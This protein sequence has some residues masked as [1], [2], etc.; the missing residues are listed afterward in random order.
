MAILPC[1][2]HYSD[3][4]MFTAALESAFDIAARRSS[5]VVLL[6]APP[7]G[8]E[9][10]YGWIEL[11]PPTETAAG[12]SPRSGSE[13]TWPAPSRHESCSQ[14]LRRTIFGNHQNRGTPVAQGQVGG[15]QSKTENR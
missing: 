10:E 1:D 2:H 6:G 9:V 5:S 11:G 12:A 14:P 3:E 4:R 13:K 7:R 8:P 15:G